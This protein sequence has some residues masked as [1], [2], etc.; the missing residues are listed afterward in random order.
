MKKALY[1]IKADTFNYN[2]PNEKRTWIKF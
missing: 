1:A 2:F